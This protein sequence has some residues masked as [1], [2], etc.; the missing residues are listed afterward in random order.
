MAGAGMKVL[1]L[2]GV[3]ALA[4]A[5][6]TP[7]VADPIITPLVTIGL[8][9]AFG[10][11]VATGAILGTTATLSGIVSSALVLGGLFG[12]EKLLSRPRGQQPSFSLPPGPVPFE[13]QG[14]AITGRFYTYGIDRV[15]GYYAFRESSGLT[16]GYGV[17]LNCRPIDG[18]EGYFI[19]DELPAMLSGAVNQSATNPATGIP[20]LITV[21]YGPDVLWP[22]SGLKWTQFYSYYYNPYTKQQVPFVMG[23][24]PVGFVEF[25]NATD[26]G[27]A[28]TLLTDDFPTLWTSAHLCRGL[29]ML[30][31]RWQAVAIAGGREAHYPRLFPVHSTVIRGAK[32]FDPRDGTQTFLV[33]GVYSIY[34]AT[35]KY[36]A[37]PAL[38]IADFLTFPEAFGLTYD[39]INWPM[40]IQAANDCD[41]FVSGFDDAPEPFAR[42]HLTWAA[43]EE[44][45][46]VLNRMLAAC[47]GQLYEDND[48]KICLW[49]GQW[50][51][52]DDSCIFGKADIS[53]LQIE[54]T[55]G[56]YA[57]SNYVQITYVEPRTNFSK[58]TSVT[59]TDDGSIAEVGER[60]TTMDLSAVHS[61]SQ[62][63]RLATRALRRQNTP[64]KITLTGGP[65]LLLAD[66]QRVVGLDLPDYGISGTFRVMGMTAQSLANI[67]LTLAMVTEDMF[68]DV[69]PPFDPVNGS[70]P[71]V[72]ISE[73]FTPDA[74]TM[75]SATG[76]ISGTSATITASVVTPTAAGDAQCVAYFRS[77]PVDVSTH[78]PLGAGTWTIWSNAIGQFSATSPT[79]TGVSGVTQCFEVQAWL[80]STQGVA[81]P[82]SASTFVNLAF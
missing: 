25:R 76:S 9:A 47:D 29:S 61:F 68:E 53:S 54:T 56:V 36:S 57:E 58:N 10:D 62:A 46:D 24:G 75:A 71:G 37:N 14:Q 50:E 64:Q 44:R 42:C 41:R 12:A 30:Y 4:L 51:E 66:G 5:F 18:V 7:A 17:V 27:F 69:V 28:S 8:T 82:Q 45:R 59:V 3:S 78:A 34:N 74:P 15:G 11:I 32:V 60:Q 55:S 1:L 13:T 23:A 72:V 31:S 26:A 16:L 22:S 35:W 38:I 73:G 2:A 70:L 80:V 6:A 40:F 43:T 48:G 65:R 67:S 81:G 19:D 63:Y 21:D 52:P 77:R 49:I 20:Y 39:D 33:D 79:I